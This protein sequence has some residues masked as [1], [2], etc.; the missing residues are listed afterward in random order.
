[1]YKDLIQTKWAQ[2]SFGES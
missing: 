2:K 1:M